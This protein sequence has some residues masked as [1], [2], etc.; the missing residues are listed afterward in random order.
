MVGGRNWLLKM[1]DVVGCLW[2]LWFCVICLSE[3]FSCVGLILLRLLCLM[4]LVR[5]L[6]VSMVCR[7]FSF[8]M[9]L[10]LLM[11]FVVLFVV[12]VGFLMVVVMFVSRVWMKFFK[13]LGLVVVKLGLIIIVNL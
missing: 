1:L 7:C 8:R 9:W 13:V 12:C 2:N 4:L 6:L 5:M 10:L 11:W 3:C